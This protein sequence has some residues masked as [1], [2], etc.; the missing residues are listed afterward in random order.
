[1]PLLMYEYTKA[2]IT[3]HPRLDLGRQVAEVPLQD[4]VFQPLFNGLECADCTGSV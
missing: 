1:M 2:I 4:V 3:M